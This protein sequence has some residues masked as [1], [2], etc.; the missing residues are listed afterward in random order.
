MML[1]MIHDLYRYNW[2]AHCRLLE[3]AKELT[4]SEVDRNLGGS[5]STVRTTLLHMLWV[6][7][8]FIRR[9]QGLSTADIAEPPLLDSVAAIQTTWEDLEK[10]RT[11]FL[12]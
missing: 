7:L 3:A 6:E 4:S 9:W 11:Q 2:W 10:E 8:M 1:E 5:F 12:T